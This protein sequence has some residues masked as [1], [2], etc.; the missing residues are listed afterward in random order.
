MEVEMLFSHPAKSAFALLLLTIGFAAPAHA[1]LNKQ[2]ISGTWYE[3]RAAATNASSIL[4]LTFTQTPT[5]QFLNITNVAC[6]VGVTSAQII[7]GM[8]L[9]A[10]TTPGQ[11][12]LGRPYPVLGAA[13]TQTTSTAKYY[14]V[15]TNQI[16]YK[17]GPGRFPSIQIDTISSGS[18]FTEANCVI[19]GNLTDN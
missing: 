11:N 14:S 13:T 5:N 17:F 19:V 1:Q 4:T 2:I 10:G 12:D 18:L 6:T 7:S 8:S 3:D 15:V 9:L 16:Y